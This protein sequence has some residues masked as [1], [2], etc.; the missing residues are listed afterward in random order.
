MPGY[1]NFADNQILT[2]ENFMD[3][4]M[5]QAVIACD[6]EADRDTGL[7]S[8]LREGMVCY[9]KDTDEILFYDGTNWVLI[10]NFADA[11]STYD[12]RDNNI[13]VAM[14]SKEFR[15]ESF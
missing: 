5:K 13:I 6:T 4:I 7:A 14:E 12:P 9:I 10:A 15:I 11:S 1:K 2:A 3:F 8:V